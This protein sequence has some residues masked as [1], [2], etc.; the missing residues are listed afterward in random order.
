MQMRRIIIFFWIFCLPA[1]EVFPQGVDY[2]SR[3]NYTGNWEDPESWDPVWTAPNDTVF[4]NDTYIN[5]YIT[6]NGSLC[7]TGEISDLIVNDTLVVKGDLFLGNNISLYINENGILIVRGNLTITNHT[8]MI[9]SGYCIITGDFK[10]NSSFFGGLF[11]SYKNPTKVFIGDSVPSAS[12]VLYPV[13]SC[14]DPPVT[15]PYPNSTC[16]YGNMAD[17]M[18]DPIY[19][20]FLTTCAIA[21]ASSNSPVCAGNTINL[22]SSG[23]TGY[24]WNGPNGFTSIAQ[25]PSISDTDAA[26]AGN[27]IVTVAD[28]NGCTD[29]DTVPVIVNALPVITAGSNTPICAG[30]TINLNS[31]GGTGYSWIGPNGFTS[32]AQS[33]SITNAEVTMT[34]NYIISV[35]DTTGCTDKDS[36][37]VM[38]NALPVVSV[39]SNSPICEENTINLTSSDGTGYTWSGPGNFTST[40]QNPSIPN[41]TISMSGVYSVTVTALTGCISTATQSVMVNEYPVAMAGPDQELNYV[42]ETQMNATLAASEKG[43]WSL[44]SGSGNIHDIHSPTTIVSQLSTGENFFLWKVQNAF[45]EASTSVKITVHDL[46][47]PS[48]ITPNGDGKNDYFKIRGGSERIEL[49]IFNRW[50]NVEYTNDNYLNDWDGR[51]S[52]N[53]ELPDDTYFY[54]VK[55][56]NGEIKKGSV[57]IIR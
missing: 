37:T 22:T 17:L 5:G 28:K 7:I 56:T 34:G 44:I 54:V 20:F 29:A 52:K 48:V 53:M 55:L 19:D 25:S 43:E 42:F 4:G 30:N 51:N 27:Y 12:N 3:D 41:A 15:I 57:L 13:L 38:V 46:F 23:G 35:T 50:G 45:C 26:M 11:Y 31:S 36:I 39:G 33:L 32:V 8:L 24:R 47:I 40:E 49:V 18:D 6:V 1:P 21:N 10:N 9:T 2:V 16:S 14:T